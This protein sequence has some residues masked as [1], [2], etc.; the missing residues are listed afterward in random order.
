MTAAALAPYRALPPNA[1]TAAAAAAQHI[2]NEQALSRSATLKLTLVTSRDGFDALAA[3][4]TELF[5]RCASCRQL[6]QDFNWLW[7]WANH[8]M[9]KAGS[10]AGHRLAIVTGHR[11]GRLVLILPFVRTHSK[12][13]SKLS[14]MG[15][16]VSQYGDVIVDQEATSHNDLRTA[17]DFC[18]KQ[19]KVDVVRLRK[20]R[21]DSTIAP[22]LQELRGI[23]TE[24]QTAPYLDFEGS[25]NY[26]HYEQRYSG[27]SRRNR[28]RQQRRLEERG[29]VSIERLPHGPMA[30]DAAT[31]A[32]TLK[33]AWLKEKG[34]VSPA[35]A[36]P[37]TS[38]FFGDALGDGPKPANC[39][40][41]LLKSNGEVAAIELTMTCRDGIAIHVIAYNLKFEKSGAGSLLMED[42]IRRACNGGL[43][44]FDLLAPGDTYKL[45]WADR[46]VDVQD[47]AIPLSLAGRTYTQAYL[48]FL[49]ARLKRAVGALPAPLRKA[50]STGFA[51]L[52][53]LSLAD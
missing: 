50:I 32:M 18:I 14:F 30:R 28:R 31:L 16:P 25:E 38:A 12:G 47:W 4:W 11:N 37:R 6:F 33:R 43:K 21:A 40:I 36:D 52:F 45:D 20:V 13:L 46:T 42:S 1:D 49:R 44:V 23:V 7:H 53:V 9:P 27:A 51:F 41:A 3:E 17:W 29:T 26:A 5:Q 15:D 8:F 22:L 39:N 48:G 35:L 24:Q 19:M 2:V 34:L 10:K